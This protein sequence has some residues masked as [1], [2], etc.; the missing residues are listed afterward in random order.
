MHFTRPTQLPVYMVVNVAIS[1]TASATAVAAA[2][3]KAFF[4]ASQGKP[5]SAYGQTVAPLPNAPTTLAPGVDIIPSAFRGLAQA[6]DGVVSVTNVFVA[7]SPP[8][9]TDA[10]LHVGRNF[11]G[12]LTGLVVNCTIFVP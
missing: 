7:T 6:Q 10:I 9:T 12:V 1:S 8:A 5:F 4:D 2:I 3:S 11:V